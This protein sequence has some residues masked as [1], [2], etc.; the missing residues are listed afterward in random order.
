MP[1]N[2]Q[3]F[4]RAAAL[5]VAVAAL[6]LP[7]AR[8]AAAAWLP[9]NPAAG[10]RWIVETENNTDDTR[11]SGNRTAL[12]KSR[13]E[14]TVDG[15]TADGFKVTYVLRGAMAE[16]NDPSLPLLRSA[17]Q[18]LGDIPIHAST[19]QDGRP[20]RVDNLDEAEAAIRG[21]VDRETADFD[22]K[23]HVVAVLH[24]MLVRLAEANAF[25]YL[26]GLPEL[27]RAPDDGAEAG[28][29]KSSFGFGYKDVLKVAA[30][31]PGKKLLSA[32]GSAMTPMQFYTALSEMEFKFHM[33]TSTQHKDDMLIKMTQ[34][35]VTE[36]HAFSYDLRKTENKS[37]T[38]TPPP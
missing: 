7:M 12:I 30:Q 5:V 15:K 18:A 27:A 24:R 2:V 10:S 34:E 26:E 8:P 25:N 31:S 4:R 14:I 36:A 1:L 16:G 11:N 9:F 17:M 6:S 19:D 37:I 33:K 29:A 13:A 28:E 38:V 21:M 23:P 20:V 35:T 3:T 32:V 22:D